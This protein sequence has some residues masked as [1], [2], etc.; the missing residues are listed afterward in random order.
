MILGEILYYIQNDNEINSFVTRCSWDR[1]FTNPLGENFLSIQQRTIKRSGTISGVGLHTGQ[2]CKLTFVPAPA[3]YGFKFVRTDL[4]SSPEIPALIDRVIDIKRG[5]TIGME[6][7]EIH[8]VEH[9]LSAMAG[10]Q[11][12]NVRVELTAAEPPVDDGSAMPFVNV[13]QQL[14]IEEQGEPRRYFEIKD[15]FTYRDEKVG[16]DLIV[17]PSDRFRVTYMIDYQHPQI[18]TQYTSLYDLKDEFVKEFASART[19]CL[20]SE[21]EY[22]LDEKLIQGGQVGSAVVY[23]DKELSPDKLGEFYR[24]FNVSEDQS[25][26]SNGVI[27][28]GDIRYPNEP[29]RHKVVDLIGDLALLGMP[30]KGHVLAAR[31]GH[32]SHVEMAKI[33]YKALQK[34][35]LQEKYQ[36]DA[37]GEFIF[38]ISAIQRILP[39]RY[40]LLLVDRILK[41]TPGEKVVGIKNVS[42]N[43]PFFQGHFPGRPIMPGVLVVEAMGQAGGVLLLNSTANPEEKLVYFTGLDKVKFRHPV[44]PGDQI[45]LEVEMVFFRRN[46]CKMKGQAFVGDKLAAEAMMQAV[47]VDR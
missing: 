8:T 22:M 4:E 2:Q 33:L 46:I 18:G 19:F 35:Q 30:I 45:R 29:V 12:D 23:V 17:L 5:T 47:I 3:N 21:L 25:F 24:R 15:T 13:L 39:H 43:E 42:I 28:G 1:N 36:D 37:T 14:G 7:V 26:A 16:T 41:L 38:D 6:G 11:L 31:A 34:Q 20:V 27:G 10:L 32:K 44:V 9:V 40:P